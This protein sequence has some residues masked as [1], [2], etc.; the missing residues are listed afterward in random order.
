M[1]ETGYASVLATLS[2]AAGYVSM[3]SAR[4]EGLRSVGVLAA[5][6]VACTFVGTTI[7]FPLLLSVRERWAQRSS[8]SSE[9]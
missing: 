8:A 2:N 7:V 1:K 3:L 5:V 9:N 4:H 6:G